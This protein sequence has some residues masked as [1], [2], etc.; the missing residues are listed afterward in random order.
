[1]HPVCFELFGRPIYWYGIMMATAFLAGVANWWH[2]GRREGRDFGFAVDLGFWAMAAGIVGARLTYVLSEW[3]YFRA[4]PLQI[5]RVDQGGLVFYGGFI[6]AVLAL[7]W[8]AA[9]RH[10]NTLALGDFAITSVPLGHMFG[11]IGC[12][13]FGCCSGT[14]GGGLLGVTFPRESLP[15][16]LQVQAGL[17]GR[18]APHSLPVHPV[19][20]YEA[21]L[22]LL[23]FLLLRRIYPRRGRPGYVLG[24]YLVCYALLRFVMELFRG[25]PR[26]KLGPFSIAQLVSFGLLLAGLSLWF[27]TR[28]HEGNTSAG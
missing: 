1:M 18:N 2:L 12:F 25:D 16:D 3:E 23:I 14:I 27:S 21:V 26:E 10:E 9:R 28:R 22:N 11:R 7:S 5:L 6:A 17:I 13:L 19:Q 20:L 8:L 15:W 24:V 4:H